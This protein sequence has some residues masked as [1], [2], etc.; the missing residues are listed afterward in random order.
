MTVAH[1]V[2]ISYAS[3]D[4]AVADAA[5]AT[6]EK[7]RIRCWVAPRDV[8][9]GVPWASAL[10]EAIRGSKV[11]VLILSQ[12]S[13]GSA[14]VIREIDEAVGD[15]VPILP[16]R[17]D[18]VEPSEQMRYYIKS[19]HWLDA[20]SPPMQRHLE[21]LT[22]SV[23]AL[24]AVDV[25]APPAPAA[26]PPVPPGPTRGRPPV[27]VRA[28]LG[29]A[30]LVIVGGGVWLAAGL[31]NRPS[32]TTQ[33]PTSEETVA[34]QETPGA[35]PSSPPDAERTPW[36][37]FEWHQY[38]VTGH[39]YALTD[40]GM[41]WET[42]EALAVQVGGHLVA[43]NDAAEEHWLMST[44]S[45]STPVDDYDGLFWIGLTRPPFP[46]E[47]NW[48]TEEPVDYVNWCPGEPTVGVS[49]GVADFRPGVPCWSAD[50]D[51]ITEFFV[52]ETGGALASYPGIIELDEMPS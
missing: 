27:W 10:V 51:N 30:A 16:L 24:L 3:E 50:W 18:D 7:R 6:L 21:H 41:S 12:G 44:F 32:A 29:V 26:P 5:C 8:P 23:E 37:G 4:K 49:S 22:D 40:T 28:L 17:I 1:D 48:T 20:L 45:P 31:V 43:V 15:G 34:S 46:L 2:F 14:Q 25:E 38:P 42:L 36:T 52:P 13:N 19:I 11:V 33:A 47:W 39:Y 35:E 9:A